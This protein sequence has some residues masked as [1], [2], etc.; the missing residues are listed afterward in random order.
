MLALSSNLTLVRPSFLPRRKFHQPLKKRAALDLKG[1]CGIYHYQ[2]SARGGLSMR[3][4]AARKRTFLYLFAWLILFSS[5]PFSLLFAAEV[6][7]SAASQSKESFNLILP[8]K[9]LTVGQGQEV[10]MDA[11]VVNRRREPVSV[12]LLIEG[13]PQ[14]WDVNFNSR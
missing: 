2:N 3:I 6:E 9:D 1:K 10:T 11:E 4:S 8:F 13:V 7:Q 14:G 12:S 5:L